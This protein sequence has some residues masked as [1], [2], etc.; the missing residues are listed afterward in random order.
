MLLYRSNRQ[1]KGERLT[2]KGFKYSDDAYAFLGKQPNN[3]WKEL[4]ASICG[5]PIPQKAGTYASAGG[6]WHNVKSLDP[7]V[8]AHI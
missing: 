1:M 8:L 5:M 2:V 7:S 6:Q 4:P 3:D